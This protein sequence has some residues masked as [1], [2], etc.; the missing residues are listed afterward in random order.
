MKR[1]RV[2]STVMP[3]W[4]ALILVVSLGNAAAQTKP[5]A[6]QP[7]KPAATAGQPAP[8][9]KAPVRRVARRPRVQAAPTRDRIIAIQNALAR[10]GFYSGKPTGKWDA[11]TSQAMRN[12]QTA[13]G[14]TPTGKLGALS[15]QRLGLGSE[16]AG[17]AAPLPQANAR[18]SA[19][20]ESDLNEPDPEPVE[21]AAN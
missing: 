21:P 13:Q 10:E 9:K 3:G 19:L 5:P 1:N 6:S 7:K 17:L 14:L 12:F 18:P 4:L 11:A 20:S 8:K 15:L 2:L 16:V